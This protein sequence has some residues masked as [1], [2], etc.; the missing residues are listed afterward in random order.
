MNNEHQTYEYIIN[1]VSFIQT[2]L[3]DMDIIYQR[4]QAKANVRLNGLERIISWSFSSQIMTKI[5][6]GI[7]RVCL[8]NPIITHF[9]QILTQMIN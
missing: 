7:L 1:V 5:N 9:I 6:F 2:S 4:A 3:C 8:A